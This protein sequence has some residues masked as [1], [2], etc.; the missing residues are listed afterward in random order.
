MGQNAYVAMIAKIFGG[1]VP[2]LGQLDQ[3]GGLQVNSLGFNAPAAFGKRMFLGANQVG[4]TISNA[5]ATVYTGLCLSNPAAS[6][7]NLYVGR[8]T[9]CLGVA[10]TGQVVLGFISGFLAAGITVHTTPVVPVPGFIGD[11]TVPVG[12]VDAACTLVGT[13]AWFEWLTSNTAA[14]SDASFSTDFDGSIVIPP[15]G[16]LAIGSLLAAGPAAGFAG[17]FEWTEI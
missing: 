9:G 10:A 17:S 3:L 14:N 11:P 16:Y 15:G 6:G 5:L 2:G 1:N 8:V 12:K 4:A 13:P 7:K